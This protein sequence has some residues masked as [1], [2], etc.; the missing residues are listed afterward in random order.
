MNTTNNFDIEYVYNNRYQ[1]SVA[2]LEGD[3]VGQAPYT[4]L[5]LP[6]LCPTR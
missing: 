6:H 2:A 1:Y 4:N 5:D 3:K